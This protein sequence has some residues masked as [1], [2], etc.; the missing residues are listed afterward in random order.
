MDGL[1]PGLNSIRPGPASEAPIGL[2]KKSRVESNKNERQQCPSRSDSEDFIGI[3]DLA[4]NFV[5]ECQNG[6]V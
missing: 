3:I 1:A 2:I 4:V 5:A 6:N